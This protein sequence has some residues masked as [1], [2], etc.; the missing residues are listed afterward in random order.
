MELQF[1]KKTCNYVRELVCQCAE[2][3]LTDEIR[4]TESMDDIGR[5]L[6]AWGQV[7]I[8]GKEWRPD[9]VAVSG[10]VM[11]WVLYM[12]ENSTQPQMT[13]AWMPFHEQWGIEDTQHDGSIIV[14]GHLTFC[15]ARSVS[16]RKLMVR[17]GLCLDVHVYAPDSED[18]YVPEQ[19]PENVQVQTVCYPVLLP[20]EA[21][22]KSFTLE[23][24]LPIPSGMPRLQKLLRYNLLPQIMETRV[25]GGRVIFRG[26]GILHVLA[27]DEEGQLHS[28]DMDLP[29]SQ[30]AQLEGGFSP[31]AQS[32]VT[33]AVTGLELEPDEEGQLRLKA[34]LTGQYL[35]D[36]REWV[37]TVS[38]AWSPFRQIQVQQQSV[39]LPSVLDSRREN[40]Y[41]EQT[42][43][44]QTDV[45]ADASLLPDFPRIR[46]EENGMTLEQSA[47]AQILS[48]DRDGQLRGTSHRMEAA[49]T[50]KADEAA[51]LSAVALG[52]SMQL[53]DQG[54]SM[55]VRAEVPVQ[56][57]STAG[58]GISMVTALA[59][60]E[61]QEPDPG[62]PSLIL[63]R[64]AGDPL[65]DIARQSGSTVEAIRRA[66]ALDGEPEPGRMLLIP[67]V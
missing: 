47:M 54:D 51:E 7:L 8:R 34:G 25:S 42:L 4:L 40:I 21:G 35:V 16:A 18:L 46:R 11:V 41:G 2:R 3:E 15:D 12:P 67:V 43:P 13:E 26:V 44:I 33:M 14:T 1:K 10:G 56:M 37:E 45:V 39:N 58:E 52:G 6:G 61:K 57:V 30:Y 9:R 63:R 24:Q 66:N 55:L 22:E 27:M 28:F 64:A 59:L 36:D 60:G 38:D 19:L 65:W 20:A 17:A 32:D 29:F 50:V 53:S 48:Y 5:V 49:G 23:E 62:R 31:D